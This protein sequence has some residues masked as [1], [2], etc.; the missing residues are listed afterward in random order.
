MSIFKKAKEKGAEEESGLKEM[1]PIERAERDFF[2]IVEEEK[3][4]RQKKAV[5][6]VQP[7]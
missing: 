5:S 6:L 3:S 2:R 4:R 7:S 1:D